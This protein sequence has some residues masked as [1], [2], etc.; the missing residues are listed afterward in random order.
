M[1]K[2]RI[3]RVVFFNQGKV[4]ELHA[5]EVGQSSMY[6]FIEVGGFVF[7]DKGGIVIDPSEE[8]LKT[9][10]EGV[11]TTFIPMHAVIRIDDVEKQGANKI[12]NLTDMGGKISQFPAPIYTPSG[13]KR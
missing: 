4:Y 6:G 7:G 8:R 1:S 10:F 9:E 5:S 11:R 3:Y 12:T 2:K 13:D